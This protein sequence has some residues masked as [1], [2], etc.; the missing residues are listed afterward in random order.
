MKPAQTQLKVLKGYQASAPAVSKGL[1]RTCRAAPRQRAQGLQ[2]Q[3]PRF[4]SEGRDRP[5]NPTAPSCARGEPRRASRTGP[6]IPESDSGQP[7]APLPRAQGGAAGEGPGRASP[8]ERR[9]PR[10]PRPGPAPGRRLWGGNAAASGAQRREGR[11]PRAPPGCFPAPPPPARGRVTSQGPEEPHRRQQHVAEHGADHSA[12]R[13]AARP[14]LLC[15]PGP[16]K[17]TRRPGPASATG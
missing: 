16:S 6:A 7:R 17:A 15:R 12:R 5:P 13:S 4:R 14:D 1:P 2:Q 10:P 9:P 11:A 8:E 3:N